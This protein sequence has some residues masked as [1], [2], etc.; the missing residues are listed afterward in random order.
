MRH[1]AK[2]SC[3]IPAVD[4]LSDR[5]RVAL[6]QSGDGAGFDVSDWVFIFLT[7]A[8]E[9]QPLS[10]IVCHYGLAFCRLTSRF[11]SIFCVVLRVPTAAG[12]RDTNGQ[13]AG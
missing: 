8:S 6:N 3:S 4:N 10:D 5:A 2:S 12:C 11:V 13:T 9:V 1:L 7:I